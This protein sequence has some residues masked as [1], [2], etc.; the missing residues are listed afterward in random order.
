MAR[1][2][3]APSYSTGGRVRSEVNMRHA[4]RGFGTSGQ[5]ASMR[6]GCV[7]FIRGVPRG[8]NERRRSEL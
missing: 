3:A 2:S 4:M 6:D 5:A 7:R 1:R 8:S